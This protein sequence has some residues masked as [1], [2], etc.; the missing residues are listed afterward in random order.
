M[1]PQTWNPEQYQKH[2]GFVAALGAPLV[3]RLAPRKGE[4]VLDLGCGDGTLTL[5][6]VRAGCHVIA[7]DSS[8]EQVAAA[9]ARG[10]DARVLRAEAL[11]FEGEFDAI[12]SNATLHWIKDAAAVAE[13][14][15]R[16]LRPGGRFVG[17]LGGAGNVARIRNAL[18]AALDRRGLPGAAFDPWYY[19]TPEAYRRVLEAA[20]FEL[21]SLEL[22]E[23]PTPLP[24]AITAWLEVMAQAFADPL[25]PAQRAL[26]FAEVQD[27]LAP[28]LQ[29]PDGS[30]WADYVRLRFS[31]RR[32]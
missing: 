4:R 22:F 1:S 21:A 12:F 23:R 13:G 15:R 3:Q 6:L 26:F 5:E 19:P 7:I 32:S 25:A 24:G 27:A 31:A 10:L 30:W 29:K 11:P 8:P 20:G 18:V 17:E 9:R 28:A 16:A 14:C 2:T